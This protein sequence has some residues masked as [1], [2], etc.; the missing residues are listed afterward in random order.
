MMK[1]KRYLLILLLL[2]L[3][4]TQSCSSIKK[5]WESITMERPKHSADKRQGEIGYPGVKTTTEQTSEENSSGITGFAGILKSTIT[6]DEKWED[7]IG[8]QAGVIYPFYKINEYMTLRAEGNISMQGAK[9]EEDDI[10][11]RTNLLYINAPVVFRY[12]TVL[13]IYG[14]AGL[15][16]GFLISAR[17]YEGTIDNYMTRMRKFDFSVPIG[18]G[19]EFRSNFGV[20]LR[21]IP[22]ISDITRYAVD[23]DRNFVM[24]LRGTYTFR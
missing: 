6:G 11:G 9:W 13:G 12:Q 7:P 5:V 21:L 18:I 22:G 8:M 4:F 15:Q 1:R 17:K 3:F 19:Y 20:G 16:P 24:T 10:K 2:S 23:K 14:E